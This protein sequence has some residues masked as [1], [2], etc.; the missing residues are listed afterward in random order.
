VLVTRL[1][2]PEGMRMNI[3]VSNLASSVTA[4]DL[5]QLFAPYGAVAMIHIAI[6]RH[7]GRSRG[8][9]S[10]AMTDRQAAQAAIAGLHGIIHAGRVL[11][12]H[13]AQPGPPP[14][15]SSRSWW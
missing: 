3:A 10:V 6:D 4:H 13:A 5:R 2:Q 7:T 15:V 1:S 8:C 9:G 11:T 14:S 12:V